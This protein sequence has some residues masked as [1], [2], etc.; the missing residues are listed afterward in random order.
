MASP[1]RFV[2]FDIEAEDLEYDPFSQRGALGRAYQL[3]GD[4]LP[5]LLEDLSERLAA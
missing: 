3:F 5:A 2:R 4:E 1:P